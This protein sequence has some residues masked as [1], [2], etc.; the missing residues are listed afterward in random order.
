MVHNGIIENFAALRSELESAGVELR[1]DTDTE[2]VAHL[3]A[4]A[5]DRGPTA[6]D[7]PASMAVVCRRA[8]ARSPWWPSHA[9]VPA[10][11]VAARRNSPL[12]VGIGDGEMFVASDVSAFIEHTRDAHRARPGPAGRRHP[13][14][15][16][17]HVVLAGHEP[18]FRASTSTGI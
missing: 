16:R 12:V 13:G 18:D 5:Y 1:S 8:R 9:D 7:L 17:H 11:L 15:L 3:L 2:V 4:M 10:M 6:G 14:R